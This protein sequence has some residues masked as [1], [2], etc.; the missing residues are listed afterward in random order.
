MRFVPPLAALADGP[1]RFFGDPHASNRPMA[2]VLEGLRQL[3]AAVDSDRLPFTITP[4][5]LG[6]AAEVVIDSS[7]SSQFLSGLLL[8]GARLAGGLRLRHA[9]SSV[10]SRP[11]IEMTIAM[12]RERGVEVA[13]TGPTSWEVNEGSI[14]ALSCRIEPDLTNAAAFLAAAAVTGGRV[15]I[16]GWPQQS[17]QP[18]GLFLDVAERLGCKAAVADGSATLEGGTLTGCDLDLHAASELTPVVAA[19]AAT[20]TGTTRIRGVAHIRGHETDRLA[21]LAR[22]LQRLGV[23]VAELEDG[24][25][26]TGGLPAGP[27]V[28]LSTYAD[29]RMAH[30]AAI[31][32]LVRQQVSVDD[33]DCVSKT[34]PD[35]AQRWAA[36]VSR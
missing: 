21:A 23:A 18:G 35:F 24:L 22:E 34:M 14:Q 25:E 31:L 9:G 11:H 17:I 13:Q 30:F 27:P 19:I 33:I 7:A 20:A 6:R 32:A 4:A 15:S 10:P 12:L 8:I 36:L 5:R 28:E 16:P 26:I 3:G 1:T 2:G 29:H